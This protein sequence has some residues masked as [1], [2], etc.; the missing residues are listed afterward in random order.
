V[1]VL[2]VELGLKLELMQ[3]PLSAPVLTPVLVLVPA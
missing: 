2:V 1:S 3:V